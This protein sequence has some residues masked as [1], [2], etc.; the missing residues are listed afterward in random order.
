MVEGEP[1]LYLNVRIRDSMCKR[2][3]AGL[4]TVVEPEEVPLHVIQA[5]AQGLADGGI[6]SLDQQRSTEIA[7]A[8]Y[9]LHGQWPFV[10]G[11]RVALEFPALDHG[12][13][14]REDRS[15]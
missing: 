14:S 15:V 7:L 2:H 8:V 10:G 6:L 1:F 9:E 13:T 11:V 3:M 4:M 5:L 12:T